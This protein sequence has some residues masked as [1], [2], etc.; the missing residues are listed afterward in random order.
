VLI[1]MPATRPIDELRRE[2][3]ALIMARME[4][5]TIAKAASELRVSRQALY[6]IRKGIY[7]PS[8]ALVQRA[9]EVWGLEFKFRGLAVGKKTLRRKPEPTDLPMQIS[10]F[11]ALESLAKQELEIVRAKRVGK[12]LEL[13]FRFKLTA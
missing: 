4:K 10:L 7:C 12:A 13:V 1:E 5:T 11:E 8:L 3:A 9:C 2:A 6:D